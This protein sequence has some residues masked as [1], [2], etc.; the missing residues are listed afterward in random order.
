MPIPISRFL[1]ALLLMVTVGNAPAQ[2]TDLEAACGGSVQ[3][4]AGT[5]MRC[6]TSG[7]QTASQNCCDNDNP[8]LTD[9][10]GADGEQ[11]QISY[12]D[13]KMDL[14][15]WLNQCDQQDQQAALLAASG[16]CVS[17]GTYCAEKWPLVGCVQ[18]AKRYCCFNSMMSRLIQEQGRE[19]LSS[20]DGFGT[21]DEPDCRGFT[22]QEFE[23]IDFT[24][25][26]FSEY[27][28]I[29]S[30]RTTEEMQDIMDDSLDDLQTS[31]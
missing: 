6:R 8:V 26:D 14:L 4:F 3:I 15:F 27:E 25:V 11:G 23:A 20:F 9:T 24:K 21:T 28:S 16:Y 13:E 19:Q 10:T 22:L 5:S 12:K 30:T 2:T 29:F 1:P 7:T 31:Y 17:L 18:H